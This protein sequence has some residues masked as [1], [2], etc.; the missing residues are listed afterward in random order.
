MLED[1]KNSYIESAN[2]LISDWKSMS[3]NDLVFEALEKRNTKYFDGYVSALMI[4]YWGKMTAYYHKSKLVAS[5]EDVHAWLVNAIMYALDKHP[6][7]NP[8]SSIYQDKNGPDKVINRVI[9]SR[10]NT[11]YQQLN[12][13]NRK[14]N[15]VMMSLDALS[16]DMLDAY[17]PVCED[18]H[19]F[20]ID[21]LIKNAFKEKDYFFAFLVDAIVTEGIQPIGRH[22][23]LVT[24]LKQLDGHADVFAC[25]YDIELYV[26]QRA[27]TYITRLHRSDLIRKINAT[28][29]DMKRKICREQMGVHDDCVSNDK[30]YS[31]NDIVEFY[32]ADLW[33]NNSE[34]EDIQC[35]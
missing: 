9:E 11:F 30:L 1:T 26:V 29:S 33:G 4:K 8:K 16:E 20:I 21:D 19:T 6:W 7:T 12:R 23:K 17:T 34:S 32:Y 28:L 14:I 10:R 3:K 15:S 2:L 22:K 31:S 5:P 27:T 35:L 24:H 13:Y 25:R 18:E